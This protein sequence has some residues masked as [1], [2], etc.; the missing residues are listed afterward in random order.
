MSGISYMYIPRIPIPGFP[1]RGKK[2]YLNL[3]ELEKLLDGK[4][5]VE[6]KL[7]GKLTEIN[8]DSLTSRG[9]RVFGE[10]LH[11]KHNICYNRLPVSSIPFVVIID[12]Y[13]P[14]RERYLSYKQ[15]FFDLTKTPTAPIL[16]AGELDLN[17]ILEILESKSAFGDQQIE[18]VVIKNYDK[19]L[20]G[21]IVNPKFDNEVDD[22]E[23][24][25]RKKRVSN[26]I[27]K[28]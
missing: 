11:W 6:E 24:W 26:R 17:E 9:L 25:L 15:V 18:G 14:K 5:F 16:L 28:E 20:F 4:I 2:K 8:I 27:I 12:I 1:V 7:D 10:D 19:Q 23:H 21:K 13:D 22:S 3:E